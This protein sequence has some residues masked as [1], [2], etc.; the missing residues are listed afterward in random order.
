MLR[1]AVYTIGSSSAGR[2]L[3]GLERRQ[4]TGD[5]M[6]DRGVRIELEA[7]DSIRYLGL[8][9]RAERVDS[10]LAYLRGGIVQCLEQLRHAGRT[11]FEQRLACSDLCDHIVAA[12][13]QSKE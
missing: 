12:A 2:V 9:H 3:R 5:R 11:D 7:A 10:C 6:S 1:S 4:R 13:V 8:T